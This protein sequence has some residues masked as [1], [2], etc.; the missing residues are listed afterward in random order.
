M[1]QPTNTSERLPRVLVIGARGALGSLVA[2]A[3]DQHHWSVIEAG[4]TPTTAPGF[5]RVD[6][7]DP[8]TLDAAFDDID[9]VV[10]TVPDLGLAAE[11]RVLQ[12]GGV[13]LNLSAEPAAAAEALRP[14]ASGARGAVVMNAGVAPGV[15]NLV[16]AALLRAH[17]DA[18]EVQMVFTV[19]TRGSG[20]TAA[21]DF[22]HR[23]LTGIRHHRTGTTALPAPFGTRRMLG[24]AELDGGWLGP[25]SDGKAVST[26]I[27]LAERPAHALMLTLNG[28]RM[29]AALPRALLGPGRRTTA[30]NASYEPVAHRVAVLAHGRSIGRRFVEG[31]GDFRM[32]AASTVVFA[33]ALLGRDGGAPIAPGVWYPEEALSLGRVG[34]ALASEGVTVTD[35][36]GRPGW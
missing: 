23:G 30:E 15:T 2:A 9:V 19:S 18:D 11:R 16:A 32:A 28:A 5:R 27:C 7:R 8:S 26:Y 6:L 36:P 35:W 17:P 34:Q 4:R 33:D 3:F 13:L 24:F 10:N 22:A 1:S 21:G 20:G 12:R 31:R 14:E 25:V 29:I